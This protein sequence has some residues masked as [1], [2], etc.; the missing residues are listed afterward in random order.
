MKS[1]SYISLDVMERDADFLWKELR[2][3]AKEGKKKINLTYE[4]RK[5]RSR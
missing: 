1:K 4:I 5:D 3:L 2:K